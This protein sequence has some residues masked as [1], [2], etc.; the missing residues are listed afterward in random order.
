MLLRQLA[1]YQ[2]G[3]LKPGQTVKCRRLLGVA[4]KLHG[5]G[6]AVSEW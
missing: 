3:Q 6:A 5:A 4:V 2:V 1:S